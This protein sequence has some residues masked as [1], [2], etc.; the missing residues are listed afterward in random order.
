MQ[1]VRR[2]FGEKLPKQVCDLAHF[3]AQI[4]PLVRPKVS[5]T[6]SAAAIVLSK[7]S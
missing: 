6:L 2:T 3:F 1:G 7:S 5:N 4:E